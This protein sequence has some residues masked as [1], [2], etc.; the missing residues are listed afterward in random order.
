[1]LHNIGEFMEHWGWVQ[2]VSTTAWLYSGIS[3][4][5]YFTLFITV[6]T[7]VMVDLRVLGLAGTRKPVVQFAQQVYPWMWGA[8]WVA[9]FSGFLEFITDAGDYLPDHVF[10]TKMATILLA[11]VFTV[12]VWRSIPKAETDKSGTLSGGSKVLAALSLIFW[13]GSILAGVEIAA[14]SGLG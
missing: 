10:E 2:Y 6:G 3:T 1:M 4:I 11:V 13:I 5:H 12:L 8:F 14:I 9:I 7:A